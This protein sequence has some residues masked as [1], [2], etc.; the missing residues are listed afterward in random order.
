MPKT[1]DMKY[2]ALGTNF[3]A[4]LP[5]QVFTLHNKLN[6]SEDRR[7]VKFCT[8]LDMR[9]HARIRDSKPMRA[10]S[11]IVQSQEIQE[12]IRNL[13]IMPG[14][15]LSRKKALFHSDLGA[16]DFILYRNGNSVSAYNW[17]EIHEASFT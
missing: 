3:Y 5:K 17:M 4:D 13:H 6:P 2:R 11:N 10:N 16:F 1:F 7:S 14:N 12:I 8:Y 15:G 9:I